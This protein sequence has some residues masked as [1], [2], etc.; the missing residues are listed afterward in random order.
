MGRRA[1]SGAC[2]CVVGGLWTDPGASPT[3]GVADGAD[4][5]ARLIASG[6]RPIRPERREGT[7]RGPHDPSARRVAHRAVRRP[8]RSRASSPQGRFADEAAV[9][10]GRALGASAPTASTCSS[11]SRARRPRSSTSTWGSAAASSSATRPRRTPRGAIRLRLESDT[12]WADLRGP[13]ICELLD[14]AGRDRVIARLGPD[15]LA[16]RRDVTAVRTRVTRSRVAIGALV[17]DQQLF[18]GVGNAFA[19]S[20]SS[21]GA[22]DR[23]PRGRRGARG[24]RRAVGGGAPAPRRRAADRP[25]VHGG[26]GRPPPGPEARRRA[27]PAAGGRGVRVRRGPG[28]GTRDVRVQARGAA[29]PSVRH[30]DPHRTSSP[31][32]TSTGARPASRPASDGS[33]EASAGWARPARRPEVPRPRPGARRGVWRA[34]GPW[35]SPR[36]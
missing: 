36:T 6:A 21:V 34:G 12:A 14:R 23:G 31:D 28:A 16:R 27:P 33:N 20:C 7:C 19:P 4:H 2:G 17:M 18:N 15:L 35:P 24:V 10:D 26:P 29:L 3:R 9:L 8:G 5:P 13:T 32:A 11:S 1:G 22:C 25:G 30:G